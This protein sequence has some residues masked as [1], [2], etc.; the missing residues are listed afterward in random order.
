MLRAAGSPQPVALGRHGP[1]VATTLAQA[2]EVLTDPSRYDFPVD[3]SRRHVRRRERR[4]RSPHEVVAPI[5]RQHASEAAAVLLEELDVALDGMGCHSSDAM[6]LL[7]RPVARSTAAAVLPDID[8][9]ARDVVADAVLGWVD[10]LGPV[11]SSA[12]PPRRWSSHRRAEH[13]AK[14]RLESLLTAL[15]MPEPV[16]D[17]TVLAAGTQV[18]IAAGA[19][20]LVA[21]AERPALQDQLSSGAVDPMSVVWEVLR[22]TPPTWITARVA[23]RDVV[24]AGVRVPNG[25]V[26]LVSPLLMG[27]LDALVPGGDDKDARNHHGVLDATR[28]QGSDV[29]PGAW[30]PFGAGPHACPGRGVGLAQLGALTSWGV[31]RRPSL[32]APVQLDQSRGIFPRPARIYVRGASEQQ[33]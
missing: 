10:C 14:A 29:R 16:R 2:R 7:R 22:L 19:W 33:K 11:I 12:R 21:L 27:R 31:E 6:Q 5:G 32:A 4:G 18:P 25:G 3:V 13:H 28:W 9:D 1:W 23:R 8:R 24:L 20:V 15:G 30:L 26:V 17:A